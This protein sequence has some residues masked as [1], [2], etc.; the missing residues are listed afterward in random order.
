MSTSVKP[1]T[2]PDINLGQQSRKRSK[3]RPTFKKIQNERQGPSICSSVLLFV[4]FS[5]VSKSSERFCS[6]ASINRGSVD[7][8]HFFM[9]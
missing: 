4:K 7:V 2:V 6:S 5:V 1:K 3:T 9:Y 8:R